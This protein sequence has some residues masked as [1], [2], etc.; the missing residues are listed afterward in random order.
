MRTRQQPRRYRRHQLQ[1]RTEP[2]T[3][4][5]RLYSAA[6]LFLVLS[7][8]LTFV[9]FRS[10][11]VKRRRTVQLLR[12]DYAAK[13]KELENLDMKVE[14][15]RSGKHILKAVARLQLGLR[16]PLPGQV[17]RIPVNPAA[18]GRAWSSRPLVATR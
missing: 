7:T 17:R 11:E 18:S 6:L 10:D 15:Y 13:A 12:R 14:T 5:W 2:G 16:P 8:A 1:T 3:R 9:W 4:A